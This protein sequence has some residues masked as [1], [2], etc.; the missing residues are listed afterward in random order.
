MPD[1]PRQR[2]VARR[3]L[4]GGVWAIGGRVFSATVAFV[5]GVV[6]ARLL[7]P[8][9]FGSY[10]LAVSVVTVVALVGGLGAD[11][12]VVRLVSAASAR[13]E[14]GTVFARRGL[15]IAIV[16]GLIAGLMLWLV[17]GPL[18]S[19][20]INAPL[21]AQNALLL[22][23]WCLSLAVQR[24]LAE[25]YRSYHDIR[26]AEIFA[27]LGRSGILSGSLFL[28]GLLALNVL[29]I[30]SYRTVVLAGIAAAAI[31]AF[32]ALIFLADR[33]R[34]RSTRP[35]SAV[36]RQMLLIAVPLGA[37]TLMLTLRGQ[38]DVW[39]VA[40][41]TG[42][43]DTALYTA[44]LRLAVLVQM[45]AMI[46]NAV[47]PP[48]ISDLH[49]VEDTGLMESLVRSVATLACVP[50]AI[51]LLIILLGGE[52]LM[53]VLYGTFYAGGTT[54][55][56]LLAIS[57][58][59]FVLAGPALVGLA[60]TGNERALLLITTVSVVVTMVAGFLAGRYYG[61]E[62]VAA[63]SATVLIMQSAAMAVLFR[64]RLGIWSIATLSPQRLH[65]LG[66]HFSFGQR[67]A[68]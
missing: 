46:V 10:A 57:H 37:A 34:V 53:T 43:G 45:P 60:M 11:Q 35:Q 27:G 5:I 28:I 9:S 1:N 39:L 32:V 26:E 67:S 66:Q 51:F 7:T 12:A 19:G 15:V 3:L 47:V 56:T 44:A 16:S 18:F 49:S 58:F 13:G 6:L 14:S 29:D 62:G 52:T 63:V 22:G 2:L 20:P 33:I 23:I 41:T 4:G 36:T 30:V 21:L 38:V 61:V 54:V 31:T 55:L 17:A 48:M 42:T 50:A 59:A 8:E 64:R 25:T 65:S 68:D 40:A 24:Q